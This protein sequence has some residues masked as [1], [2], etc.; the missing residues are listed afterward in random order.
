VGRLVEER[1]RKKHRIRNEAGSGWGGS[2][3]THKWVCDVPQ[4]VPVP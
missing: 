2:G 3:D 4:Y 1:R